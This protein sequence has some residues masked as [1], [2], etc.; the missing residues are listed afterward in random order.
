MNLSDLKIISYELEPGVV[1]SR[2][3]GNYGEK[4]AIYRNKFCLC[5]KIIDG[6]YYFIL[7]PNPSSR[8]GKHLREHRFESPEKAFKFW[9]E[10]RLLIK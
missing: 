4:W 5:K 9:I 1:L 2:T 8:T 10:N 6:K 7:E 3:L